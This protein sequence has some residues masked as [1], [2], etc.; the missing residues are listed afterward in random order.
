MWTFRLLRLYGKP[1][2][3]TWEVAFWKLQI[4]RLT[5]FEKLIW[6][7]SDS[8]V[9]RSIDWLFQRPGM[10]AQR[11]DWYCRLK[12]SNVCSGIMMVYP[13]LADYD[14][15]LEYAQTLKELPSGDQQLISQYFINKR[16]SAFNLLSD[17]DAAFGQCLGKA[18][19]PYLN[20]DRSPVWGFWSVPA[21]VH[22]S[23][24]WQN[25]NDEEYSN[26]C[27][28]INVTRQRYV[29]GNITI[30]VCH[31][32]PLGTYWRSHFCEAARILALRSPEVAVYC[33]DSCFYLGKKSQ[34]ADWEDW[35]V[36]STRDLCGSLSTTIRY[37]DYN[38]RLVG[39]PPL[40]ALR[41]KG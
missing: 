32:H 7:D 39:W 35:N 28:S 5:Q 8:L 15:L 25:A 12:Q 3:D 10:W 24:G 29:V 1:T 2:H 9:S 40:E 17:V 20:H 13:D 14:G 26:V 27:F 21:F 4:W 16:H 23:G 11:D 22:K 30:N 6:L 19:T 41:H 36:G 34:F 38:A 33:Q 18:P 37:L 31:F